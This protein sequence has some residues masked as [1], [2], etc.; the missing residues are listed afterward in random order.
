MKSDFQFVHVQEKN[1]NGSTLTNSK[2]DIICS[3]FVS[4]KNRKQQ[5]QQTNKQMKQTNKQ[6]STP[7][8]E[9][10]FSIFVFLLEKL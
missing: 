6:K 10:R 9:V 7:D 5:Q 3:I 4:L 8:N 1:K 2:T